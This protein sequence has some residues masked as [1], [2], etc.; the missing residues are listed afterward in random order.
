MSLWGV[1][2]LRILCLRKVLTFCVLFCVGNSAV[3][4]RKYAYAALR[5]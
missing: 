1:L 5:S 2:S 3:I 4:V